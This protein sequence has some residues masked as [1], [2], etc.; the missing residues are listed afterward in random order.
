MAAGRLQGKVAVIT[1]GSSGIGAATVRRFCAEGARV[2]IGDVDDVGG[3]GLLEGLRAGGAEVVYQRC[4]VALEAEVE[5][6]LGVALAKFGGLDVVFNNAGIAGIPM[7]LLETEASAWDQSLAVNLRGVF[8]GVKHAGRTMR[9]R[10]IHGSIIS[11]ASVAG[12][13][14][15]RGPIAYS[16]AKAGVIN[17]TRQAAIELAPL[18]IRVNCI[19]PGGIVTPI[20]TRHVA[21]EFIAPILAK[22]QPIARA[23]RPD[24]IANAALYLASDESSFV[25]GECLVVDGALTAGSRNPMTSAGSEELMA[26]LQ[27]GAARS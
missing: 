18:G 7:P 27:A 16:A 8:L 11:T 2:V 12:L 24:D 4:D 10:G 3:A 5:A 19:A 14:G 13:G 22:A 17:L 26:A 23:G 20:F 21:E 6:L 15:G 9:E 1:G 25:S